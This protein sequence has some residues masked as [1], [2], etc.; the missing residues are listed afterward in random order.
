MKRF[1]LFALTAFAFLLL[2]PAIAD[3][4]SA[5]DPHSLTYEDAAMHFTAPKE[6]QRL[7]APPAQ[8][9]GSLSTVAIFA[10]NPGRP[11][12]RTIMIAVEPYE[13]TIDGFESNSENELRTQID[14]VFVDHKTRTVLANGMPAWWQK[15]SYGEGLGQTYR[16]Y[17]YAAFDGQRGIMV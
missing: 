3:E 13:G 10:K 2:A 17:G 16:R 5:V 15:V 6:Y 1:L 11:E 7:Q 9:S 4:I 8:N 12:Q 14:G